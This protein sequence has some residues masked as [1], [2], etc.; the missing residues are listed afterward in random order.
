M[1]TFRNHKALFLW[2]FMALYIGFVAALTYILIQHGPPEGFSVATT[3]MIMMTFWVGGIG[4]TLFV[5]DRP[6]ITLKV[7]TNLTVHILHR[8]PFS[9][10]QRKFTNQQIEFA[11]AVETLDSDGNRYFIGRTKLVDGTSIDFIESHS[12]KSCE[13]V[14]KRFNQTVFGITTDIELERDF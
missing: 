2:V 3:V 7:E 1:V 9:S 14:C 4:G 6:C 5:A 12:F 11:R 13:A 10:F 8:Y